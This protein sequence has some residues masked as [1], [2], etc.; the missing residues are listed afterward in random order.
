MPCG[1]QRRRGTVTADRSAAASRRRSQDQPDRVLVAA[2]SAQ[3]AARLLLSIMSTSGA[4]RESTSSRLS[5]VLR[6]RLTSE[7]VGASSSAS[8][9]SEV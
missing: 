2:E 6:E 4:P 9:W 8:R 7:C 1:S 5:R 3:L